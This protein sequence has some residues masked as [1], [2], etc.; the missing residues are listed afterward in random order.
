[1]IE[2]YYIHQADHFQSHY[3]HSH[4]ISH[5][6]KYDQRFFFSLARIG[7][8]MINTGVSS[9]RQWKIIYHGAWDEI[10]VA[11]YVLFYLLYTRDILLALGSTGIHSNILIGDRERSEW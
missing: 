9:R 4:S 2:G 8:H 3:H 6:S 5:N 7:L 10:K 1:M 11:K